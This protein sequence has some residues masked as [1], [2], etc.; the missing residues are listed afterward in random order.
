MNEYKKLNDQPLK[1]VVAEFCFTKILDIAKYIPKLQD[2]L[3]KKYP[4]LDQRPNQSI[5]I[6]AGS[7]SMST[8]DIWSFVSEN[9]KSAV[10]IHQDRLIY[11]TSEYPRFEGFHKACAEAVQFLVDIVDP[12]L[13]S[14]IGLRYSDLVIVD[15]S[16]NEKMESLVE[17]SFLFPDSVQSL[18]NTQHQRTETILK[19]D[20]GNLAIRTLYGV[21]GLTCFQ[22]IKSI[23]IFVDED[24]EPSERTILD[25]DHFWQSGTNPVKFKAEEILDKLNSLHETSR[26]AFWSVTTD[27]AR[28]EKWA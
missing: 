18:G 11:Y 19:T 5:Q 27:Y 2:A 8:T 4:N 24:N 26:E 7:I 3:R 12:T 23:P 6:Q 15:K 9:K 28:N 1:F 20:L 21:H 13:V 10:E 17:K 25:F 22:D 14:R 16:K